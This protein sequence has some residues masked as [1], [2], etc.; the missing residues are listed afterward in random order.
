MERGIYSHLKILLLYVQAS[1]HASSPFHLVFHSCRFVRIG[2][3]IVEVTHELSDQR[4]EGVI[5]YVLSLEAILEEHDI[6]LPHCEKNIEK[7][8]EST[9]H[10]HTQHSH[11]HVEEAKE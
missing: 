10:S 8:K 7:L 2:H 3:G 4:Y 11:T 6:D 1:S 9:S 5:E